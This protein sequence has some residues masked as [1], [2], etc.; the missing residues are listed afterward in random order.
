M[1]FLKI[2]STLFIDVTEY[3]MSHIFNINKG[4][5]LPSLRLAVTKNGRYNPEKLFYALQNASIYFTMIDRVSNVKVVARSQANLAIRK[6]GCEDE[7]ILEYRWKERDTQRPGTYRGLFEIKFN[8]D[9][10]VEG[11]SEF[12]GGTLIVPIS[13]ELTINVIEGSVSK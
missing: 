7:F 2:E 8:D 9:L 12:I 1:L 13:H 3:S 5:T 10:K 4:S 6:E 11:Y